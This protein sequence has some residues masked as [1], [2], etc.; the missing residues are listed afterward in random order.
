[1]SSKS[2]AAQRRF[3][4]ALAAGASREVFA[5]HFNNAARLNQ[6]APISPGETPTQAARRL[7]KAA[8]S[9]LID[10]LKTAGVEP[11]KVANPYAKAPRR[12]F[13]EVREPVKLE[14]VE[15]GLDVDLTY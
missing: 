2:T 15:V 6:N 12:P 5:E 7:T 14:P 9:A 8:A 3:I 11:G 13:L 4:E 1:M 10:S